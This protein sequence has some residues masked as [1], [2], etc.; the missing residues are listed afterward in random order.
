MSVSNFPIPAN[1]THPSEPA[2]PTC[3]KIRELPAEYP[4]NIVKEMSDGGATYGCDTTNKIRRFELIYDGLTYAQAKILDDHRAEAVDTF[5]G[6]N[7][8]FYRASTSPVIDELL[9][10]VHYES[11]SSDHNKF[12]LTQSRQIVLVKR[13]T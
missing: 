9:S 3:L 4:S 7:F 10:D 2:G 6:F 13:P 1:S 12:N 11:W 5:L 8:R